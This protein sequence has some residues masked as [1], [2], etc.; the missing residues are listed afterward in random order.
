MRG[1]TDGNV[2]GPIQGI[3]H[4]VL[5]IRPRRAAENDHCQRARTV[6][7]AHES[8]IGR[9]FEQRAQFHRETIALADRLQIL[10]E[11]CSLGR[12]NVLLARHIAGCRT[13]MHSPAIEH[14][15][16][17][18]RAVTGRNEPGTHVPVGRAFHLGI[19]V[20]SQ[21]IAQASIEDA[22]MRGIGGVQEQHGIPIRLEIGIQRTVAANKVFVR[23]KQRRVFMALDHA[24][25]DRDTIGIQAIVVIDRQ[26]ITAGGLLHGHAQCRG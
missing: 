3:E 2:A 16:N 1:K 24:R 25:D 10:F 9:P 4:V 7:F 20:D 6:L 14:L 15:G 5:I 26:N 21:A 13:G 22:Q 12:M 8:P 23:V 19:G 17:V 11:H 18:D